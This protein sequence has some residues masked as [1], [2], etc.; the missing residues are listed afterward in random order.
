MLFAIILTLVVI[1]GG[2]VVTYLYDDDANFGLRLCAG[3][4]LGL[5][6]FGLVGFVF[7]LLMGLTP[8]SVCASPAV[9]ALPL[10]LLTN[11]Q[12]LKAVQSDI[13]RTFSAIWASVTHPSLSATG[14]L[15]FFLA[16]AVLMWLVFDRV[17]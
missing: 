6:S 13:S 1:A 12:R 10:L 16:F 14:T 3:A 11:P 5:T 4:C 8:F 2:T 17:I 15:L 9:V 7:V